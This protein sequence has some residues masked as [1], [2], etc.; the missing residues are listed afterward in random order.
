LSVWVWDKIAPRYGLSARIV[1]WGGCYFGC[2][3]VS[4]QGIASIGTCKSDQV[5]AGAFSQR[6]QAEKASC[7]LNAGS[8]VAERLVVA[9]GRGRCSLNRGDRLM[10]RGYFEPSPEHCSELDL[11][12]PIPARNEFEPHTPYAAVLSLR[13]SPGGAHLTELASQP[14][15]RKHDDG[16]QELRGGTQA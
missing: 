4:P 15:P 1:H 12:G 10:G 6:R 3:A 5:Q 13:V 8:R 16:G 2:R 9:A 7:A 11:R 14:A